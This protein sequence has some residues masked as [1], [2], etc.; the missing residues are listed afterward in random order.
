MPLT[1]EWVGD[2]RNVA[3]DDSGHSVIVASRREN[4]PA[5]FS[6]T[7]LLLIAAASC[8]SNH[9]VGILQK[10]RLSIKKL[11]V[12]ADGIRSEEHPR[13]FTS[14]ALAFEVQGN[15]EQRVFDD[16]VA[17]VKDKY[18]SVLNSLDQA[19]AVKLESRILAE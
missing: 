11:R 15:V 10:K 18:C 16:M 4:I 2:L 1:I 19:I 13:K 3:S 8:M 12:L 14:I 5:G 17:M 9:L 7:Q 6:A